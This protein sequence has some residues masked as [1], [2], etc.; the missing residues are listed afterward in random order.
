[1]KKT[2]LFITLLFLGA[3]VFAQ[4]K[5]TV[6]KETNTNNGR[7]ESAVKQNAALSSAEIEKDNK[8]TFV[9]V[10]GDRIESLSYI[11]KCDPATVESVKIIKGPN[12]ENPEIKIIMV[13]TKK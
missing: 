4:N 8:S 7:I 12:A 13:K 3:T 11:Q 5:T 2:T 6:Q 9:I 1:M 10:D